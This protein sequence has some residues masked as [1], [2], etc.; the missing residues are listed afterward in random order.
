MTT[1]RRIT[2]AIVLADD[3][4]SKLGLVDT[5]KCLADVGGKSVLHRQVEALAGIDNVTVVAGC[6][7][8]DVLEKLKTLEPQLSD[9]LMIR[10]INNPLWAITKTLVSLLTGMQ[11]VFYNT[12]S[13]DTLVVIDD[14]I[15]L[16]D[17]ELRRLLSA[18]DE[19][20]ISIM[21]AVDNS[22][23]IAV[24][25]NGW[26]IGLGEDGFAR[27]ISRSYASL[28][29][30]GGVLIVKDASNI[31]SFY[32]ALIGRLQ[33]EPAFDSYYNDAIRSAYLSGMRLTVL[34]VYSM[35]LLTE[36]DIQATVDALEAWK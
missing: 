33:T 4:G 31:D 5:P 29:W 13:P 24:T 25:I 20:D 15:V 8:T 21:A 17:G 14:G 22:S 3:D 34:P 27:F 28:L 11:D 10:V 36:G 23:N 19:L 9:S 26:R 6:R 35:G 1:K 32:K 7:A 18:A 12:G 2:T 30:Y 16:K